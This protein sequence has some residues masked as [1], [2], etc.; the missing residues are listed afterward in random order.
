MINSRAAAIA[1]S[2][3]I[4]NPLLAEARPH[5]DQSAEVSRFEDGF[6][7]ALARNDVAALRQYLSDDWMIVSGD[8]RL[9]TRSK[10]LDVIAS[11]DLKHDKMSSQDQTIRLYGDAALVTSRAKSAGSYRGVEFHTDEVGTDVIVRRAGRWVCVLTQL[12]PVA[13]GK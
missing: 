9:I 6:S 3:A 11:G 7:S 4:F 10:F 5:S 8:G 1:M 2:I 12:T 13:A